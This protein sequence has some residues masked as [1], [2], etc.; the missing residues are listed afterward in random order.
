M[1]VFV[2][3]VADPSI[4]CDTVNKCRRGRKHD[5]WHSNIRVCYKV[6]DASA[7]QS[8]FAECTADLTQCL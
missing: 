5:V 3:E 1:V 7:T 2:I 8:S 6:T 4:H